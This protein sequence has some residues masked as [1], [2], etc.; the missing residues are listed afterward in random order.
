MRERLHK[1]FHPPKKTNLPLLGH[2]NVRAL[3]DDR[4]RRQVDP[5]RERG[6]A[7]EHHDRSVV[8]HLLGEPPIVPEHARVVHPHAVAEVLPKLLV[9]ALLGPVGVLGAGLVLFG[10]AGEEGVEL[11]LEGG[12]LGER[13]GRCAGALSGVDEDHALISLPERVGHDLVAYVV[14]LLFPLEPVPTRRYTDE[15]LLEGHGT[16]VCFGMHISAAH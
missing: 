15:S 6:R 16:A 14:H 2:V 4:V 9:A 5:P 8:E 12:A 13:A 11:A 1:H 7:A 10:V 3:D